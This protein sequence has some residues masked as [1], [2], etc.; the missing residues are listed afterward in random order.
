MNRSTK[1]VRLLSRRSRS[2]KLSS[3]IREYEAEHGKI[4]NEKRKKRRGDDDA[5]KAKKQE[6]NGKK[7]S[8]KK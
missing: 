6:D 8:T 7:D 3:I 1:T 4:K 2:K 5:K